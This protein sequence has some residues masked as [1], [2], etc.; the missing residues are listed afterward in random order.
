MT[1]YEVIQGLRLEKCFRR[2]S[3][4]VGR[5]IT[6]FQGR[7]LLIDANLPDVIVLINV[8]GYDWRNSLHRLTNQ[9]ERRATDWREFI[10]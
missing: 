8:P 6:I 3:W 1:F 10:I 7:I 5:A 9:M 2:E 4:P